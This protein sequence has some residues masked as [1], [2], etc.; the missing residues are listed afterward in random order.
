MSVKLFK[1]GLSCAQYGELP[2]NYLL[3]THEDIMTTVPDPLEVS[4]VR[5]EICFCSNN[6]ERGTMM[7]MGVSECD[8]YTMKMSN[9]DRTNIHKLYPVTFGGTG[10]RPN[11]TVMVQHC[12]LL[13]NVTIGNFN[14]I[15]CWW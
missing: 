15:W 9:P 3:E 2:Y 4:P 12:R 11:R 8:T 10:R 7:F 1:P 5:T 6:T 14:E 13:G